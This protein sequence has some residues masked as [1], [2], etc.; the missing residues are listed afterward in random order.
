M[1]Y[2]YVNGMIKAL[3]N[4]ILDRNKLFVLNKYEKHD[5]VRILKSMNYGENG[6]TIEELIDEELKSFRD[7]IK[8]VAPKT[9]DIDLFYLSFDA[10]NVKV[11][12]K[13]K[14]YQYDG[15]NA[16]NTFSS[17]EINALKKAILDDDFSLLS[18]EEK[19]LIT[20]VKESTFDSPKNLCANVDNL[21][22]QYA[23]NKTNDNILKKYIKLKIDFTNLISITRARL[24]NMSIDDYFKMF[25]EN[26]LIKKDIFTTLL[27]LEKSEWA[28]IL[29]PFYDGKLTKL[30]LKDLN[31]SDY[32]LEYDRLTLE[33]MSEYKNDAFTIGPVIYYYLMKLSEAQ[34]IRILYAL[35]NARIDDLI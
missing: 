13:M 30:L 25:I 26:G 14:N 24:L 20:L 16:L 32:Q 12:M 7:L 2:P 11:L 15:T 3:E 17:V 29:E 6:N 31:I 33:V 4:K 8:E 21:I 10:L 28:K 22:Y 18:K 19:K 5:F 34:N 9:T 27:T 35:D 1:D 23:L